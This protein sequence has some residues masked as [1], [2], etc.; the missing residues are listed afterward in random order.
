MAPTLFLFLGGGSPT[1]RRNRFNRRPPGRLPPAFSL[2][3]NRQGA[4]SPFQREGRGR[5]P[6]EVLHAEKLW[7]TPGRD[8]PPFWPARRRARL[9]PLLFLKKGAQQSERASTG[10]REKPVPA[11]A[12]LLALLGGK[13]EAGA[14]QDKNP[15]SAVLESAAGAQAEQAL[16]EQENEGKGNRQTGIE[17]SG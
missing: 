14:E 12:R 17:T 2:L 5:R 4:L 7:S 10:G 6:A 3:G 1:R 13:E 11:Q 16:V 8:W 15:S 9:L